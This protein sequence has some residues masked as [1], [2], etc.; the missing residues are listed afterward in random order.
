M[1]LNEL[2]PAEGSKRNR[3]RVGRGAGS[4]WGKT[5]SR[6]QK[7]QKSRSGGGVRPGFE[8]GQQPLQIRIPKFGFRSRI[9]M[10]T[11]E[12]RT[13]E[14]NGIEGDEITLQKLIAANVI[15]RD[16]RRVRIMLSGDVTRA[17]KISGDGIKVTKGALAAIE[18]AGGSVA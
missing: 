17:V 5:A 4:G 15:R 18:G 2:H 9:G 7:G 1:Q 12:V 11:G 8:G 13:S 10:V 14:L 16:I 3:K 6:G